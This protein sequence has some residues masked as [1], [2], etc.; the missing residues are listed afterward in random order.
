MEK[1]DNTG[2][3]FR[4]AYLRRFRRKTRRGTAISPRDSGTSRRRSSLDSGIDAKLFFSDL[5]D[6]SCGNFEPIRFDRRCYASIEL[7]NW[8]ILL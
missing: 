1:R 4:Y 6:D 2:P 5:F 8:L 7:N 3:F